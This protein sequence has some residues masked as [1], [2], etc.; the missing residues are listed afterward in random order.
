MP[1]LLSRIAQEHLI[2]DEGG[3]EAGFGRAMES[4]RRKVFDAGMGPNGREL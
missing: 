2:L 3:Q 1:I 4:G